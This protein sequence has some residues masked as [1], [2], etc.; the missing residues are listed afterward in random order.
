VAKSIKLQVHYLRWL[1]KINYDPVESYG[2]REL[3]EISKTMTTVPGIQCAW[4]HPEIESRFAKTQFIYRVRI[5][6]ITIEQPQIFI[7]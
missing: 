5:T 3:A 4:V 2:P 1:A 7:I 6:N